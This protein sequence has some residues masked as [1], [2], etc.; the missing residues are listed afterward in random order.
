[1]L[2]N[3]FL[4]LILLSPGAGILLHELSLSSIHSQEPGHTITHLSDNICAFSCLGGRWALFP[5]FVARSLT[6]VGGWD[7]LRP[8]WDANPANLSRPRTICGAGEV[9]E[10]WLEVRAG[11][12]FSCKSVPPGGATVPV[13]SPR[14]IKRICAQQPNLAALCWPVQERET[15]AGK[16][17]GGQKVAKYR[18][19][20]S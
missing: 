14:L 4:I 7:A 13:L 19:G 20:G 15:A 17:R 2:P 18:S 3:C 5:K 12:W 11:S 16:R 10:R 1:M 8:N 9:S 6:G